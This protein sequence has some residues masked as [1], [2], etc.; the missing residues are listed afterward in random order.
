VVSAALEMKFQSFEGFK[1]SKWQGTDPA[2]VSW[3][4]ETLKR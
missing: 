1:V 4:F 2:R 3:D